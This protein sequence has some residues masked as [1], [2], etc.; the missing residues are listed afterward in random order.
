[1]EDRAAHVVHD[2]V[3]GAA[4]LAVAGRIAEAV[5]VCG[6]S[7]EGGED[8]GALVVPPRPITAPAC[9]ICAGIWSAWIGSGMW[10]GDGPR[11]GL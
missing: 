9:P 7:L 8:L 10:E 5:A 2:A 11:P 3:R 6:V 1:M 4:H